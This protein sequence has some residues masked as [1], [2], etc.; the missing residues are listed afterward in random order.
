MNVKAFHQQ[1][2]QMPIQDG[3]REHA[4]KHLKMFYLFCS[5]FQ[6]TERCLE[7]HFKSCWYHDAVED[8]DLVVGI[9]GILQTPGPGN[10]WKGSV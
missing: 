7:I 5:L 6:E 8:R 4:A 1:Q 10:P 9:K 3:F 2:Q